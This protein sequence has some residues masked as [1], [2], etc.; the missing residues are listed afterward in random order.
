TGGSTVIADAALPMLPLA[1]RKRNTTFVVP[2]GNSVL[3]LVSITNALIVACGTRRTGAGSCRST[4]D[5]PAR[6]ASTRCDAGDAATLPRAPLASVAAT[7]IGAGGVT[8]GGVVST[9]FA[10]A[11]WTVT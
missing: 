2:T 6:N 7:V 9:R 11:F 5:P 1:S 4:A 3:A 8:T 10:T